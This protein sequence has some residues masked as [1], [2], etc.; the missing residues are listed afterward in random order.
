MSGFSL[1]AR[2]VVVFL[3]LIVL[4]VVQG[5]L[6]LYVQREASKALDH[7][8][9]TQRIL[10]EHNEIGR[11][12]ATMHSAQ[13][14]FLI[15]G[16]DS[17]LQQYD[18]QYRRYRRIAADIE[19]FI[20]DAQQRA[21]FERIQELIED[22]HANGS[23]A[24]IERR[25]RGEDVVPLLTSVA[26]PRFETVRLELE[27]FERR[28]TELSET[29]A[30][31]ARGRVDRATVMITG[32]SIA[33]IVI[34]IG[35]LIATSR[36]ILR[37]L[38]SIAESA[39]QL[40]AGDYGAPLPTAGH[41]EIGA[42]VRAF[43]EMRDAVQ[44]R[45][46]ETA[47]AYHEARTAHADLEAVIQ[48][49]PAA[50]IIVNPDS[51]LRLQNRAAEHLLGKA[52][53]GAAAEAYWRSFVYRDGSGKIVELEDLPAMR[54]FKGVEVLGEELQLH[55]PG[56]TPITI[57]ISAAPVRDEK[58]NVTAVAAGFLDITRLRELDRMKDE[59]VSVVSHELRTPLTAIRGSLQLLL[60]D[61]ESVPDSD[62]RQLLEVALKSCERLVRII[63]DILDIS[64]MEAGQ[65]KL[66]RRPLSIPDVAQQSIESVQQIAEQAGVRF[67][68]DIP[69]TLPPAMADNDRLTQAL[70]NLLSNAVK[71]APP[72]SVVTVTAR[73]R[74][75]DILLSVR[76]QGQGIPPDDVSRL[77]QK[78]Q[79]L[80]SSS[81]RRVGG[82][83][84]GLAITKAI[85]EEHGGGISVE[86]TIGEGTTFTVTIPG[87]EGLTEAPPVESAPPP[88]PLARPSEFSVLIVD[89]DEEMRAMLRHSMEVAGLR[90]FEA[91]TG[92]AA[93]E[94]A[95]HERPD[96]ITL[97]LEMP[98]GDGWW[99]IDQLRADPVTAQIPVL[100]VTA[101]DADTS[102]TPHPV[103]RKPFDTTDL[104]SDVSR[105][106]QTQGGTVLVA[107]DD[108]EVRYVLR[109]ALQRKGLKVI[110]AADGRQALEMAESQPF[111]LVVLDLHMPFVHGHDIIRA[112]RH[113]DRKRRVPIIALSGSVGERHSMQSL[114]LGASVFMMKPPDAFALAREV[115]RLLRK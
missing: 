70:V 61:P 25:Q 63:N 82:T 69:H 31:I 42:L 11:A 27:L 115:E 72:D 36:W 106:L 15:T 35:L 89:D 28:L 81:S 17:E 112:L 9:R 12:L 51:S 16:A 78:F 105:L 53:V 68:I 14:G 67:D 32:G 29:A 7:V 66:K 23:T 54:A 77:F 92:R 30:A 8:E 5:A 38:A 19:P 41:T 56:Q 3:F 21:R 34:V 97:D 109:E 90:V 91:G 103:V 64:K 43:A 111:D 37:P 46:R 58:G 13:R 95:K 100:V 75:S 60:A 49:V 59:F 110:E 47:A 20:E 93:V 74:N 87:A 85:V 57:M 80:D 98:G 22:W 48:T 52:P 101:T 96:A 18:A 94:R 114:V 79:Q 108:A 24:V 86:S 71:F 104:L 84:L 10:H 83:G 1:R 39:R 50:L 102:T 6:V 33:T 73:E 55:R 76:D 4:G 62:N 26:E 65:L 40:A 107:D 2:V 44:Q 45:D 113:P 99:V 88:S